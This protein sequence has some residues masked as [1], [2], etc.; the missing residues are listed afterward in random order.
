LLGV[1]QDGFSVP[2]ELKEEARLLN[3]LLSG[4]TVS[5]QFEKRYRRRDGSAIWA[6]ASVSVLR[7]GGAPLC[8]L[9]QSHDLTE[10]KNAEWRLARLAH[11]DPLTG[12]ANRAWLNDEI[13]RQIAVARR[14]VQRFAVVFIDLDHFK[15]VNDSLGHEAGDELLKLVAMKLKA[16]LRETDS[17]ARLGGDEFVMLLPE[18]RGPD[19]VLVVTDK[20]Q[21][22]C[23]RPVM[24]AGH[25]IS[26]GISVG[27]S[28]FPDDAQD[29]RTLLRYADSALYH[30]K[31]EGRNTL[32]FYQ[33]ELTERVEQRMKLGAG[34][35]LALRRNEFEICYQPLVSLADG[36]AVAVEALMRWRHPG[37]GLLQPNAFIPLAE[38]SGLSVPIGDWML[39]EAC[40]QAAGWEALGG[41]P[42]MVAVNVSPRQFSHGDLVAVTRNALEESGLPP[43]RLTMEITEQLLLEHTEA[44]LEVLARLRDMGIAIAI[45]DFGS[46]YSSL[47]Y[48]RR[49]HPAKM[50]IDISLIRQVAENADDA[51]L[52]RAAISMAHQ[53]QVT[54][55][56]EGVE[57]VEQE[58]FLK[59]EGCDMG[60][61]FLYARPMPGAE[62][63]AWMR[64]RAS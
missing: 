45:D 54:V 27:V 34:L 1:S 33:P 60:Q 35:R 39:H 26:I 61:G 19:D 46:G 40:R 59:A 5:A 51:A 14:R 4:Q 7:Q 58:A 43:Q 64:A 32:R 52:V 28:L 53:L 31:A 29:A 17:V 62:M 12:L 63:L 57:T 8:Y 42:L 18:V 50:K 37:M 47:S 6:L 16:S 20:L 56:A 23:A 49:F 44:N 48:I 25:E 3:E 30:A 38:E 41:P 24:L 15:G 55:V 21:N 36:K 11:F 2:G 9:W 13:E 22:E 10:R